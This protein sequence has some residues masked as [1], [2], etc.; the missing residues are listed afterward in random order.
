MSPNAMYFLFNDIQTIQLG[1]A[2]IRNLKIKSFV[3][4]Y[5]FGSATLQEANFI[6]ECC[7]LQLQDTEGRIF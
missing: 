6:V 7:M 4:L 5:W 1:M 2:E 3:L